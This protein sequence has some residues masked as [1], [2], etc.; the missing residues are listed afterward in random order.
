MCLYLASTHRVFHK[1]FLPKS[2]GDQLVT[3]KILVKTAVITFFFQLMLTKM[4]PLKRQST[5]FRFCKA[6]GKN[7][8]KEQQAF[9]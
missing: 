6:F 5:A 9:H 1:Q 7:K 3:L 2:K 4:F 8:G